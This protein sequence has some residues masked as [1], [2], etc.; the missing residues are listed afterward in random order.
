MAGAGG[1]KGVTSLG[2]LRTLGDW[3]RWTAAR[4][5]E[6]G[7][8]CG[9]GMAD[10]LDEAAYLVLHALGLPPEVP[11]PVYDTTLTAAE[12]AA[13]QTLVRRRVEERRPAAYLTQEAWFCGLRFYVDERVLVPRSPIAELIEENFAPWLGEERE[14]RRILDLGTGSGC[15]AIACAYAFPDAVVDAVDISTD[16]LAVARHNI[17]RHRL[18]E[19]VF[20]VHS[21]LFAALKG[22]RYDLIVSNPP[23]VSE[24]EME[25]LPREYGHEPAQGLVAAHDGLEFALRILEGAPAH[26]RQDG[27]LVV[28]VGAGRAPLER[29]LPTLP[30]VWLEFRRGGEGVFLLT[31]ED[32]AAHRQAI[33]EAC[34]GI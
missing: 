21:D 28:E 30:F 13:V 25:T 17:R 22:R 7:V 19:R 34:R 18:M 16:A 1:T 24:A 11:P 5:D 9:H 14:V 15:I 3:I 23:Y 8:C 4:L 20:P 32:L 29:R 26:L 6:A 10:T 33:L 27:I 2:A 31:A 12:E